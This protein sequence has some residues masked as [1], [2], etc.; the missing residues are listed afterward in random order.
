MDPNEYLMKYQYSL[1]HLHLLS[2]SKTSLLY[3]SNNYNN[4]RE[5]RTQAETSARFF[6]S[7]NSTI[8]RWTDHVLHGE[9]FAGKP[10]GRNASNREWEHAKCSENRNLVHYSTVS[11]PARR[12]CSRISLDTGST[13]SVWT[14]SSFL[15]LIEHALKKYFWLQET[16]NQN[17]SVQTYSHLIR[18]E[19]RGERHCRSVH[20]DHNSGDLEPIEQLSYTVLVERRRESS[21]MY[22]WLLAMY[23]KKSITDGL[24]NQN[25]SSWIKGREPFIPLDTE[26]WNLA[27]RQEFVKPFVWPIVE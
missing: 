21:D 25:T 7:V 1:S 20:A 18:Q 12:S 3:I 24:W 6:F 11:P 2:S 27:K 17:S 14:R 4:S 19:F 13:W 26:L 10:A 8:H 15:P 23:C 16:R 5:I 9:I 22:S